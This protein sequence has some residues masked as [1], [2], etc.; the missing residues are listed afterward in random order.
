M[1][2]TTHEYEPDL[3]DETGA[4]VLRGRLIRSVTVHDAA[5]TEEDRAW[6]QADKANAASMCPA[7]CGNYL[8]ESTDP[9]RAG[10]W[11]V[12]QPTVC[13]ACRALEKAKAPYRANDVEPG[14]LFHA[15]LQER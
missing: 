6:A 11:E 15:R 5:W 9:D 8:D 10:Q 1:S 13:F 4:V 12:P 7:G 3:V 14:H 2:E